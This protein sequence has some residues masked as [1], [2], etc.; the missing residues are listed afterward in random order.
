MAAAALPHSVS[1]YEYLHSIYEP[2]MDY[3]DGV[4]EDRNVGELDHYLVQ[5]ALLLALHRFE[6]Q[7]SFFVVQETRMQITPT[8]FRVPDTCLV[9]PDQL[10]QII[11]IPPLLC[12]EVPSPEDRYARLRQHCLDYLRMGVPE[13]WILDPADRAL[14]ALRSDD[15]TITYRTGE[16][17]ISGTPVRLSL[18]ELFG[19][20]ENSPKKVRS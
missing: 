10:E 3:V 17:P 5:R 13:V 12:I 19:S 11:T 1:V 7:G 18:Q 6:A 8:R 20:L 16:L 14:H 15:A 4:L 9:R 2:D